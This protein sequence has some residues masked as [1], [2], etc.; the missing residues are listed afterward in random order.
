[1]L[2]YR[3]LALLALAAY[4]PF[5]FLRSLAG[6][7]RLGDVRGRLG[8]AEYPDLSGGIWL[9]AVSVGEIGVARN[10]IAALRRAR[11]DLRIG[12]SVTTEAG[13]DLALR[14]FS[15]ETPV[16]PF[17]FDLDGPVEKSLDRVRP[18]A[19]VLTETELWPLFLERTARRGI[20]VALVNGRISTR[21]YGRYRLVRPWFAATLRRV[22]LLA[23]Q[24]AADARR[25]EA[26]GA[27]SDRVCVLGNVKF[28]LPPARP[29]PDAARLR[30]AA[31][32]RP[33]LVAGSTREG[34]EEI[35]L[36]A[37]SRLPGRPLLVLAPRRP[38]RFDAVAEEVARR[39]LRLLRRSSPTRSGDGAASR[40]DAYL[41]DSIG[42]LAS[43]Y[44]EATIAFVGGSLLPHGGQNPIEAWAAGVPVLCGP[45]MENF[46][47]VAAAG[48]AGGFL[49]RAS[50]APSL[51]RALAKALADPTE[52][53][54]RG[55]AAAGF[56]AANRGAADRTAAAVLALVRR[57]SGGTG[58]VS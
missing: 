6:R 38:E 35:L 13:R 8:R 7:R 45:H 49:E 15:G 21:S 19:V 52:T 1:L 29:F 30:E 20:P 2:L 39:G 22:T 58:S 55:A 5:A 12:V 31:D 57:T 16:F 17:P 14:T 44:G 46:R 56:V 24:S 53:A 54:R 37:W 34:E 23:M 41:L 50:D 26:I 47:D 4:A 28:D 40:P 10:L 42:E 25:V 18:G 27:P 9:H 51:L 48:E 33:V 36:D 32:G 43:A 11:P 3:A